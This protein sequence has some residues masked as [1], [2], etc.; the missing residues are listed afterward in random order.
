MSPLAQWRARWTLNT[1]THGFVVTTLALDSLHA[2]H[3]HTATMSYYGYPYVAP[4]TPLYSSIAAEAAVSA[5][6]ARARSAA[7]VAAATPYYPTYSTVS[8]QIAVDAAVSASVARARSAAAVAAATPYY[9][10]GAGA[11]AASIAASNA[12]TTAAIVESESIRRAHL[13]AATA[14]YYYY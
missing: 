9:P 14:P 2:T 11:A 1:T 12:A 5:S 7:A 6:V 13:G 3:T 4:V 8:S 10:Y